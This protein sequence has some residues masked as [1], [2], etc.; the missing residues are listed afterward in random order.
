MIFRMFQDNFSTYVGQ[1]LPLGSIEF[2]F[3]YI[4]LF[5]FLF[6][7]YMKTSTFMK[8]LETE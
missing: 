4:Y 2:F 1:P 3:I 8:T 6:F 5:F 7:S